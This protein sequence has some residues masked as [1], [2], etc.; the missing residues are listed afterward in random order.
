MRRAAVVGVVCAGIVI[1]VAGVVLARPSPRGA[2]TNDLFVNLNGAQQVP[3]PGDPD[4]SGAA[5]ITLKPGPGQVCVDLRFAKIA[6]PIAMHI[7]K[8][9][10]G[11]AGPIFID[12]SSVLT[13]TRCVSAPPAKIIAVKN[14]PT[15]FYLNIHTD[16]FPAGAIRGQLKA[17]QF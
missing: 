13:G 8:G 10:V 11:T 17:S 12:L 7:H 3:D 1:L 14:N 4:G 9:G 5:L 6:T 15:G 2:A 16:P